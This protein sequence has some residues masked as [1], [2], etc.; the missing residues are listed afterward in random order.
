MIIKKSKTY[1][2]IQVIL[3]LLAVI[4]YL[5]SIYYELYLV[6][7]ALAFANEGWALKGKLQ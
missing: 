2:C 1:R 3:I 7:A 4:N 5:Y 6:L